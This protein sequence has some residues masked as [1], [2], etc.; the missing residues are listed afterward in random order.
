MEFRITTAVLAHIRVHAASSADEVCG[1]L[2]GQAQRV[3]SA[4]P[5]AN[6][7]ADPGTAFEIDPSAL[8]AAHRAARAG[9]LAVLGHYHS[10]PT[11]CAVPSITDAH[12]ADEAGVLWLIVAGDRIEG[13]VS[14]HGGSVA[15]RF[16]GA[17][18]QPEP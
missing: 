8:V 3:V 1:L 16:E 18:L 9:G 14:H 5:T 4:V 13:W 7:A 11:G 2:L 15:G 10:H 12:M 17:T 6:V